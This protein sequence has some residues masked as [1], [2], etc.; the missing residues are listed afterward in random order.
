LPGTED[1]YTLYASTF[2][3]YP[4]ATRCRLLLSIK[5]KVFSTRSRLSAS[6]RLPYQQGRLPSSIK[7]AFLDVFTKDNC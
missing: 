3:A 1:P 2:I 7:D 4:L 6:T 5:A